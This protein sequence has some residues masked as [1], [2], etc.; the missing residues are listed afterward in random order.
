MLLEAPVEERVRSA[1]RQR[2]RARRYQTSWLIRSVLRPAGRPAARRPRAHP[3]NEG[4]PTAAVG[5]HRRLGK[6]TSMREGFELPR[7]DDRRF[8]SCV[9]HLHKGISQ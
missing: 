4:W 5:P 2:D 3:V 7:R 6:P 1:F 8:T 9:V